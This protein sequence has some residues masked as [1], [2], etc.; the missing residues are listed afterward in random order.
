MNEFDWHRR[1]IRELMLSFCLWRLLLAISRERSEVISRLYFFLVLLL[2][3]RMKQL[4][5]HY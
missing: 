5:V 4:I 3:E 2:L 1:L